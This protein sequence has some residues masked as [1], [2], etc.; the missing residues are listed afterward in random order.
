ME[1]LKAI[2][3]SAPLYEFKKNETFFYPD[4]RLLMATYSVDRADIKGLVPPPLTIGK[5]PMVI[6]YVAYFK[7]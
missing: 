3:V 6:C 1:R 4:A 7:D 5:S 2:P